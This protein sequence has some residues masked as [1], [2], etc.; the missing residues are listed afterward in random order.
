LFLDLT[1]LPCRPHFDRTF[2]GFVAGELRMSL[3][4]QIRKQAMGYLSAQGGAGAPAG[5]EAGAP[6]AESEGGAADIFGHGG[7][8]GLVARL[9]QKGLGDVVASWVGK[10]ENLPISPEQLKHGLG[11]EM[12]DQIGAKLGLPPGQAAAFL[13]KYLPGAVDK[14]T[15]DGEV[16]ESPA[17]DEPALTEEATQ[18]TEG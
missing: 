14:M 10:G 15:P 17:A 9:N 13:A 12:I 4:E 3:F 18:E 5:T 6:A 11:Q 7:L 8:G 2:D 1:A 16:P